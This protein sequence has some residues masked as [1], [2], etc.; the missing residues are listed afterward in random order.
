MNRLRPDRMT[1]SMIITTLVALTTLAYLYTVF[2][3]RFV[4]GGFF[5]GH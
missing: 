2:L 3:G 4:H 5:N 1:V